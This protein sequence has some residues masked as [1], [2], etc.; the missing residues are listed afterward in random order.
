YTQA[1]ERLVKPAIGNLPVYG[2]RRSQIAAMLDG[3]E[4]NNGAVM[5]DR[6]LAYL[7]S[8]LNWYAGRDDDFTVPRLKGLKRATGR[9]RERVLQDDEIRAVWKT[10]G[11]A[12]VFGSV[13]RFL[14]LT[15]QRRGDVL[16]MVW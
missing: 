9:G 4:N 16:G 10:A 6:T 5:A 12:G 7:G 15:G 13:V 14:L 11:T 3:I 8:A 2:L 1:F